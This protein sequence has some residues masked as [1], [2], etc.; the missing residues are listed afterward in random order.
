MKTSI[1]L[2]IAAF[3]VAIFILSMQAEDYTYTTNNG[4]TPAG[5]VTHSATVTDDGI[6]KSV[7]LP[8]TNSSH[9]FRLRRP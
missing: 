3:G 7:T 2:T 6:N 1:R 5:W 8:A 4:T 9:F